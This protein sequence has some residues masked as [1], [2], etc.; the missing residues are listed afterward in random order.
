MESETLEHADF[1]DDNLFEVYAFLQYSQLRNN[2]I[3]QYHRIV[4]VTQIKNI[5]FTL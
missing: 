3:L 2:E 4:L 1:S 5:K